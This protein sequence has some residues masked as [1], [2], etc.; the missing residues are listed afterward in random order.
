LANNVIFSTTPLAIAGVAPSAMATS[1]VNTV[2]RLQGGNG[3][4]YLSVTWI[5][6][7]GI[8]AGNIWYYCPVAISQNAA[9]ISQVQM[10]ITKVSE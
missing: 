2:G 10:F 4:T 6:N 7:P 9:T 5:D 8:T 1:L 3:G